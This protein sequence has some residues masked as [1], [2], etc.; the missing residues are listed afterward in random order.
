M[1]QLGLTRDDNIVLNNEHTSKNNL[2]I[3]NVQ[4]IINLPFPSEILVSLQLEILDELFYPCGNFW[5]TRYRKIQIGFL[6]HLTSRCY[7]FLVH[8]CN[9]LDKGAVHVTQN[10]LT[11]VY[12]A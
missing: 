7:F 3:L 6:L 9:R 4:I 11:T 1:L 8:S 5:H 2:H 10:M 12:R